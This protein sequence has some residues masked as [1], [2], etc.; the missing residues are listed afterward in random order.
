MRQKRAYAF[1]LC[2]VALAAIAFVASSLGTIEWTVATI[3]LSNRTEGNASETANSS[4]SKCQVRRTLGLFLARDNK[5]GNCLQ[6]GDEKTYNVYNDEVLSFSHGALHAVVVFCGLSVIFGFLAMA[7]AAL[8]ICQD[9]YE[10]CYTTVGILAYTVAAC[11]CCL[12][13]VLVYVGLF[14]VQLTNPI[15][16]TRASG[17]EINVYGDQGYVVESAYFGYSFFL[18]VVAVITYLLGIVIVLASEKDVGAKIKKSCCM[19]QEQTQ[20]KDFMMF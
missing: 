18:L 4:L 5:D 11:S 6:P 10:T 13:S 1:A 19:Q 3:V 15:L 14:Y 8:N 7:I 17:A 16:Y 12:L 2:T 20:N 9:P